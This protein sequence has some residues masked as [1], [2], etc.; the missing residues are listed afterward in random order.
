MLGEAFLRAGEFDLVHSHVDYLAYP[1]ERLV[2]TPVVHT[3][4]GRLDLPWLSEIYRRY[5]ELRLVSISAAQRAPLPGVRFL[6]TVHHGLPRELYRFRP[7]AGEHLL[8]LG[9]ISPEKG[10][11]AA[12]AAARRA[13]VRL[14]L[15]AKVDPVDRE[16]FERD[17]RPELDPPRV[18][19]VGEVDDAEKQ[20]LLG[21]AR[22]LLLP[23]DWPEPFGLAFIE[24]LACGTP[25]VTCP[26]GSV[27]EIVREG[28]NGFVAADVD[29]L[30]DAIGQLGRIERAAC[31][32]DF[33]RRFTVERM[34]DGYEALYR[35]VLEP[36][37][38]RGEELTRA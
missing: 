21:G 22:A 15:A 17:V 26:C 33:E 25:I 3:L 23:V 28:V 5:P 11:L 6:G 29:G 20:E 35:R 30:A 37:R 31:R 8:F 2:R 38:E 19:Y 14:L 7:R 10:P 9:R 34:A 4:H 13:G 24:A 16:F 1:F 18:E 12:I 36:L 27:P 32:A